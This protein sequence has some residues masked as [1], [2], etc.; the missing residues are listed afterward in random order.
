MP[1]R[2]APPL[3]D[4]N[5]LRLR[6]ALLSAAL[7]HGALDPERLNTILT[8]SGAASLAEELRQER[9][10]AFSFTRR[11]ADPERAL[12]DLVLVIDTL[13]AQPGLMA[14]LDAATERLKETGDEAAFQE[15]QRLRE[16]RDEAERQ[17]AALMEGDSG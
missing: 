11:D 7:L 3:A 6:D 16:A 13:A 2:R 14:A 1:T 12:R 8:G 4:R 15:Q 10:L 9:G 5:A 17:L